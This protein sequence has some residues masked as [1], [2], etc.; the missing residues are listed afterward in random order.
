M[1]P[2]LGN[3]RHGQAPGSKSGL[4]FRGAQDIGASSWAYL[5]LLVAPRLAG[6]PQPA[7]A[8]THGE[9]RWPHASCSAARRQAT[10]TDTTSE[11]PMGPSLAASDGEKR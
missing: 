11:P 3:G 1:P 2:P 9:A 7:P 8:A 6:G 10:G 4:T 5:S